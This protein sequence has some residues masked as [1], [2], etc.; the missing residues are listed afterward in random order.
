MALEPVFDYID[1]LVPANPADTDNVSEGDD[2]LRGTKSALQGNVTGDATETRLLVGGAEAVLATAQVLSYARASDFADMQLELRSA[3]QL[4]IAQLEVDSAGPVRLRAMVSISP[5]SLHGLGAGGDQE[6][7]RAEPDGPVTLNYDGVAA[8]ASAVYGL[9]VYDTDAEEPALA[10]RGLSQA[11]VASF[12]ATAG[13]VNLDASQSQPLLLRVN[14]EAA[15]QVGAQ[16]E[17]GGPAIFGY[18]GDERLATSLTGAAITAPDTPTLDFDEGSGTVGLIAAASDAL[19]VIGGAD[20]QLLVNGGDLGVLSKALGST[21][22]YQA[23]VA[24]V[25]TT[26]TGGAVYSSQPALQW[27]T[28]QGNAP[29]FEA[30]ASSFAAL[31]VAAGDYELRANRTAL[32]GDGEVYFAA[33]ATTRQASMSYQGAQR[34]RAIDTGPGNSGAEVLDGGGAWKPVGYNVMPN[35]AG[36]TRTIGVTDTGGK[37]RYVGSGTL[38]VPAAGGLP[39]DCTVTVIN[40]HAS[41][42]VII[43]QGSGASLIWMSGA[44][45]FSGSRTLGPGSWCTLTKVGNTATWNMAGNGLS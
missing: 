45:V 16:F 37:I 10:L 38:T 6:L 22:L 8:A 13:V 5:V 15:P 34:L 9:N 2:H 7:L 32:G 44:G 33:D 36:T 39:D 41:S 12:A 23:D 35:K 4:P 25:G 1:D 28:G 14:A 19:R 21:L 18:A 43:A 30:K 40:A 42:T 17:P 20:V 31:E 11:L 26:P 3:S 29:F 27:A 24:K